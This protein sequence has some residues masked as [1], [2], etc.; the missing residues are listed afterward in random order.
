MAE[1]LRDDSWGFRLLFAGLAALWLF[2][3]MLPLRSEGG[4]WPGPDLLLCLTFA[5]A[6]RRPDYVPPLLV[7][8]VVFL[9]DMLTLR[10][11]GI[12]ALAVLLG[13]EFLRGRAVLMREVPFLLEWAVVAAVMTAA[14]LFVRVVQAVAFVPQPPL[15][16]ALV[17][18][19]A[20]LLA[21]PLVVLV[22]HHVFRVRK[23]ATGEVDALGR[24]L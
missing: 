13:S 6:L 12:W 16:A 4:G 9:E 17:H 22:S 21:Y 1:Q 15:G 18:L 2:L 14:M 7:A 3:R 24:R 5:W 8:G 19:V 10:A 23:P 20:T 11:P